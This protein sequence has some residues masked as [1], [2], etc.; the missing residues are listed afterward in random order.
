MFDLIIRNGTVVDGAGAERRK[1]DVAVKNGVIVKV[2][3]AIPERAAREVDATGLV[4]APGWVDIHT[5][6]DGQAT[7]DDELGP[8]AWHGVT[9][10]VMGNCGVG[11]APVKPDKH[12]WLIALMEGVEDIPGAALAEGITWGWESFPEYLDALEKMPRSV[13][14][15]AQIPHGAVRAYVMG[16][17]ANDQT[18]TAADVARMAE[19][20]EDG[21]R[22]G[23][24]GFSTSRTILHRAKDGVP[25]PG[26][27]AGAEEL[28][29]IAEAMGKAGH[30]V[31][32]M[33][34]DMAPA[35]QE[36]AWMRELSRSTGV[37][38][39]FA[40]LQ[41][42]MHPN[43]WRELLHMAN[44]A[45]D[46]GANVYAQ[47][48]IRPTGLVLGWESTVNPFSFQPSYQ[49]I[50]HLPIK[51]RLER[52]RDPEIRARI[53]AERPPIEGELAVLRMILA[54]GFDRMFRL[55]TPTGPDYEP[56]PDA[57][58]AALAARTGQDPRALVYDMLMEKDGRGYVYLPLLNYAEFNFDHIHEMLQSDR[59]VLS[60]SDGGAHC[61]VICDASFPTY[62][63][64][65]W[66][67]D[68]SRGARITLEQAVKRQCADTARLYGMHDRGVLAPG[69]RADINVID[70]DALG[71]DAPEIVYDLPA[72]GRR[73]IQRAKGYR[74]TFVAGV[75]TFRD[76]VST[77][78]K[79]GR[80]VRG[81]QKAPTLAAA[82]E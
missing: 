22:A 74:H 25:V 46:D 3:P 73:L 1:A 72:G 24:L 2:A 44:A 50:A 76:G 66:V 10:L 58:V 59:T 64:T 61:G 65:H 48:A 19:I 78:A 26:T 63:L 38:V 71:I 41:S 52:L 27:F 18:A 68:R 8:S 6:Y 14:V 31:F 79:P 15:V 16:E 33:A 11:F 4:V 77:G 80:L 12:D 43:G 51:E 54:Q 39:T 29:G 30:G 21:M 56:A 60:L 62:L 53:I 67:R 28:I 55:M 37:P 57:S 7:W 36:F 17:R 45:N 13:D 70:F 5:H 47:I 23:A 34:S 40:M 9:T 69:M 20:V 32:E 82:A 35:P 42:P 75:E 49:A 81:T